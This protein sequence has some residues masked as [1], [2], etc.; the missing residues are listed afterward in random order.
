[1]ARRSATLE[2][3]AISETAAMSGQWSR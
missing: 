2:A 3:G 1:M